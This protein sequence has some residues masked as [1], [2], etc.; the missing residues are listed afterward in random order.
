MLRYLISLNVGNSVMLNFTPS[1]RSMSCSDSD[2]A[3]KLT[4]LSHLVTYA[5][6][7][8]SVDPSLKGSGVVHTL[9]RDRARVDVR[10]DV[11]WA[12]HVGVLLS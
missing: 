3:K 11:K 1:L 5:P 10:V 9:F 4:L 2:L 7:D 12:V 8:S 6:V